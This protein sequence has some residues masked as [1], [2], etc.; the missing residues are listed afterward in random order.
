MR[1]VIACLI[2]AA[3]LM[4]ADAAAASDDNSV[5]HIIGFG[6]GSCGNWTAS[7]REYSPD[8]RITPSSLVHVKQI[9]WVLGY[10]SGV[11]KFTASIDPLNNMDGEGVMAWIDNYC[12]DHPVE[13]IV[14]AATAF[15][16]AHL[17]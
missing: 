15:V 7:A 17:R 16:G 3:V 8:R 10:L 12:R 6:R 11:G 5:V 4:I 1:R 9:Q 13:Q 2:L 14:E